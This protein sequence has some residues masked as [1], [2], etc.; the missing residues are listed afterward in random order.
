MG[1]ENLTG[2]ILTNF[3]SLP[4]GCFLDG[5]VVKNLFANIEN[6]GSI[7]GRGRSPGERMVA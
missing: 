4:T 2:T 5:S 1:R 7:P 6:V 3:L